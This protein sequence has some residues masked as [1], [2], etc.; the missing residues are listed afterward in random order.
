MDYK[1]IQYFHDDDDDDVDDNSII[2]LYRH[3]QSVSIRLLDYISH[4]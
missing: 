1:Q 2:D 3:N 4:W